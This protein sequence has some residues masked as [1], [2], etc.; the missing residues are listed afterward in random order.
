MK[1]KVHFL[2]SMMAF[3]TILVF[4]TSTVLS[5]AWGDLETILLVK[6][7]ILWG[8]LILIP[9]MAIAGGSGMSL[10]GRRKDAPARAKR[11]RMPLI[12]A[13]GMLILLP[14]AIFLESRARLGQFDQT[15]AAVQVIELVAGALNLTLMGLNI[16]DGI[17]MARRRRGPVSNKNR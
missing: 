12:A 15:Y 17:R 5:Q 10:G 4:W 11:K 1:R 2:A 8:M 13:N 9:A 6:T 7:D 16:R 3:F 14:A